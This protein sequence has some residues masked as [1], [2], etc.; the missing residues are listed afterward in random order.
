MNPTRVLREALARG[1]QLS[2]EGRMHH[3]WRDRD[4][5]ELVAFADEQA[6]YRWMAKRLEDEPA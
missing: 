4:G 3:V 1:Y 6:A 5:T 2:E